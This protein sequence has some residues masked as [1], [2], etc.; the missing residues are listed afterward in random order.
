MTVSVV[1]R[2]RIYINM[3]V[4]LS[5]YPFESPHLTPV[6]F[7]VWVW[8]MGEVHKIVKDTPDE[9]LAPILVAAVRI[10]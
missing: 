7:C 5:G 2:N 3:F 10:K 4:I 8:M 6:D 9:L 1:V